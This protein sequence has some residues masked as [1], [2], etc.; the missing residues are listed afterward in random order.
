MINKHNETARIGKYSTMKLAD[1]R[2]YYGECYN[3]KNETSYE[4]KKKGLFCA[5]K[6]CK[7]EPIIKA[8]RGGNR[9]GGKYG[10]I[11]NAD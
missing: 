8:N 9:R 3:C 10:V 4:D 1:A 5:V 2:E 7:Y 6:K 11:E